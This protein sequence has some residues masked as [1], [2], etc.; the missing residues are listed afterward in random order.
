MKNIILLLQF[1][2]NN[3]ITQHEKKCIRKYIG[4]NIHLISKNIFKEELILS[5]KTFSKISGIIIGGS[6]EFSFSKKE[7]YPDLWAKIK[8]NIPFINKAIRKNI[9]ILGICLGHQ[10]LSYILDSKIINHEKQKEVGT[11]EIHLTQMGKLDP[12]FNKIP[13][14]FLAQEGHEDCVM[15]LPDKATL[16][17]TSKKCKIQAF[18]FKNVY[19]IQFHPELS[20]IKDVKFR[21]KLSPDYIPKNKKIIFKQSPFSKK[22]LKNFLFLNK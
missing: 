18:R 21:A 4:K 20:D 13:S 12:L 9:P 17:A 2:K 3:L 1:R 8:N 19:G 11:F 10:Y 5:E 16:L 7:Q 6:G 15:E 22:I 14:E